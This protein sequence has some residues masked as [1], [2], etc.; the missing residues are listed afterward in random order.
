[1]PRRSARG[2]S[3]RRAGV[4][5]LDDDVPETVVDDDYGCPA[6]ETHMLSRATSCCYQKL[7][8]DPSCCLDQQFA[9]GVSSKEFNR[10]GTAWTCSN[11]TGCYDEQMGARGTDRM[12]IPDGADCRTPRVLYIHGGSWMYG[13]P[14][15]SSYDRFGS[16]LAAISGAV[17]F[18][19]DYP[20]VPYGTYPTILQAAIDG[21]QWLAVHGPDDSCDGDTHAPL[22][23]GGDSSGGGTALSVVLTVANDPQLIGNRKLAGTFLYSPWTNLM[24]NTPEY[25]TNAFAKIH[26]KSTFRNLHPL[27]Q[28]VGDIIFQEVTENNADEFSA[29]ALEYVGSNASLQTDPIASP[30]FAPLE[31]FSTKNMPPIHIA[32]GGSESILGDSVRVANMAAMAG[33]DVRVMV[34]TGMWHV[35]PMYSEGCGS[36]SEL[37][38]AKR[39]INETG[40]FI[41]EIA[42]L[43]PDAT[44]VPD[45]HR[46]IGGHPHVQIMYDPYVDRFARVGELIPNTQYRFND[47]MRHIATAPQWVI[48]S[49]LGTSATIIFILGFLLGGIADFGGRK[50]MDR[51]Q[52]VAR[53]RAS[54]VEVP[55]EYVNF[56]YSNSSSN[57]NNTFGR[58]RSF[59]EDFVMG[60]PDERTWRVDTVRAK[61]GSDDEETA[62]AARAENQ[63]WRKM[64]IEQMRGTY[65]PP[66]PPEQSPIVETLEESRCVHELIAEV[67]DS[68]VQDSWAVATKEAKDGGVEAARRENLAW[69]MRSKPDA[70]SQ[71][72][73]GSP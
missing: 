58:R 2:I 43:A 68:G 28:F 15:G 49:G 6:D 24:C 34:F 63:A 70:S 40:D 56:H 46:S 4:A 72:S 48:V 37:W 47:F 64:A 11:Y 54:V 62:S 20:L 5:N 50:A 65:Q 33:A 17:V 38:P 14:T 3:K 36:K 16:K 18:V 29:N 26:S 69:R 66:E 45:K 32:V 60:V 23:V 13:S 61:R 27:Q 59:I 35:F 19:I 21:L 1:M 51:A 44:A 25:Y 71:S 42:Q 67:K 73:R 31:V 8:Q 22:F 39:A 30:Y 52:R 12:W 57:A 41:K 9:D 53:Y 7:V 55:L 10:P